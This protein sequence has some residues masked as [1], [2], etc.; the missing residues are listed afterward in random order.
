MS[1]TNKLLGNYSPYICNLVYDI[2]VRLLFIELA[3]DPVKQ[4]AVFRIV[5]PEITLYSESNN[6]DKP[7]DEYVDDV[8]SIDEETTGVYLISTYKK[9]IRIEAG[10][11]PFTEKIR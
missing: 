6:L 5:F 10:S 3:D 2:D 1:L 9:Q 4:Q 8:V 7:D 11:P